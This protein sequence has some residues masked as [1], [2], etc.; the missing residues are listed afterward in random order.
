MLRVPDFIVY[1]CVIILIEAMLKKF[2]DRESGKIVERTVMNAITI[3]CVVF[4]FDNGSLEV[5]LVQHGEGI[6]KGEW[7]FP[8][9]WI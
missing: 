8:G 9:G 1:S 6:R 5:L 3:D 4:G 2:I 7:G